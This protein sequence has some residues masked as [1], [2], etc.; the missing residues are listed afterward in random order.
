MM[1]LK[2]QNPMHR[3]RTMLRRRRS[4]LL[5]PLLFFFGA[6]VTT[7]PAWAAAAAYNMVQQQQQPDPTSGVVAGFRDEDFLI[8][9][10]VPETSGRSV[11]HGLFRTGISILRDVV[12]PPAALAAVGSIVLMQQVLHHWRKSSS[13]LWLLRTIRRRRRRMKGRGTSVM[14]ED[15]ATTAAAALDDDTGKDVAAVPQERHQ[16]A[17]VEEIGPEEV[18]TERIQEMNNYIYKNDD[19]NSNNV[20]AIAEDEKERQHSSAGVE[21]NVVVAPP[22]PQ[23]Q[24]EAAVVEPDYEALLVQ[25]SKNWAADHDRWELLQQELI[26]QTNYWKARSTTLEYQHALSLQSLRQEMVAR[27]A[28]ETVALQRSFRA[29][30]QELRAKLQR[31]EESSIEEEA[32]EEEQ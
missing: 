13:S 9:V 11:H 28:D 25:L 23:Q 16:D 15:E 10:V 7:A 2:N 6:A 27:L 17:K 8:G 32:E 5:G 1:D 30:A 22:P 24:Q 20:G 12:P 29:Q 14:E 31:A 19:D 3:K 21:A 18:P 26:E 4:S